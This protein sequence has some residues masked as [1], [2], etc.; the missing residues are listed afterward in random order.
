MWQRGAP[1]MPFEATLAP[2][3]MPMYEA[4]ITTQ[5][6]LRLL[7]SC[8]PARPL[9]YQVR[10]SMDTWRSLFTPLHS[11]TTM[12]R[13][14]K[15][16]LCQHSQYYRKRGARVLFASP[17]A[18][19]RTDFT[20]ARMPAQSE[21]KARS[22]LP[23]AASLGRTPSRT[24]LISPLSSI[25]HACCDMCKSPLHL[26]IQQPACCVRHNHPRCTCCAVLQTCGGAAHLHLRDQVVG[27]AD[28]AKVYDTLQVVPLRLVERDQLRTPPPDLGR[29]KTTS[30]VP[31][32]W[33]NFV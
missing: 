2:H 13:C 27:L 7:H 5:C 10:P 32:Y 3:S 9:T 11:C 19:A 14:R 24:C 22:A 26:L 4:P 28:C 20:L 8:D 31:T 1:S 15:H 33:Q 23:A 12:K 18:C 25:L 30:R 21:S 16:A 29:D 6:P 17:T